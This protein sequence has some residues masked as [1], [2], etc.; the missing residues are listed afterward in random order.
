MKYHTLFFD[1]DGTLFDYKKAEKIALQ[2]TFKSFFTFSQ[3]GDIF[4]VYHM[5]NAACWE[6][7]EK[8]IIDNKTLRL[9]RF[10]E[11]FEHYHLEGDPGAF[12]TKYLENLSLG[13]WTHP[14]AGELLKKLQGNFRMAALTNGIGDVQ[15]SRISRSGL[16]DFFE[17]VV[18][19]DIVGCAK[20]DRKIFEYT[21]DKMG[22][23]SPR[24]VLM[25]GDSLSSDITG[26]INA[27][28]DTC[29][30]NPGH[31]PSGTL[32]P[33]YTVASLDELYLLLTEKGGVL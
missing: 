27:G 28:L 8:G 4:S 1:L 2:D 25:I 21:M 29:W 16:E 23:T 33:T 11:L 31:K 15:K 13:G 20:P 19:S 14:G 9:R 6:D 12:S 30:F 10:A 7:Y 18:I 5:I 3:P 17:V 24:G 22:I 32:D 26:G